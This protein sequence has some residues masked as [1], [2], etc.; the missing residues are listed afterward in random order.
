MIKDGW[1]RVLDSMNLIESLDCRTLIRL[2][3]VKNLNISETLIKEYVKIVEK[4][5]PNFFE[6]KGFTLQAKALLINERLKSE[7]PLQEYF[8]D[9]N[10]LYKIALKFEEFSN[11]PIIYANETSRDILFAVNWNKDVNPIIK[12]P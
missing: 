9:Y 4:A 3:A 2:T 8:P 6:I 10:Y 1:N 12:E 5:N 11:F 7:R